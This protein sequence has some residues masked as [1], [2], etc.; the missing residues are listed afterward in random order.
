MFHY[1]TV[2]AQAR[3]LAFFLGG[4]GR[5]LRGRFRIVPYEE[6]LPAG[7]RAELPRGHY[8]FTCINVG[9]G[10][11]NP[12]S[13]VRVAAN[14]LHARLVELHGPGR[15]LTHPDR[16]LGRYDLLKEL[17]RRGINRFDAWRPGEAP[18]RFPAF[19]RDGPGWSTRE[20]ALLDE[21]RYRAALAAEEPGNDRLAVEFCDTA[22]H[23]G[24]YRKYGALVIGG[25]VV[26]RH[27]FFSRSWF[28]KSSTSFP[29]PGHLREELA[30]LESNPH[31]GLMREACRIGGFG[32]GRVD[33]SLLDG[34]PQIWEINHT[35]LLAF[36][37]GSHVD[38][39]R[40]VNQRFAELFSS[41]LDRL[42]SS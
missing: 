14:A 25:E 34:K 24:W 33:F 35:P 36:A 22:S 3:S 17:H 9:L 40:D 15:V 31:A 12:P 5:A 7:A 23:D 2:A 42:E 16:T 41:A 10:S 20:P 30:Y 29:G 32:Y 19:L 1:L 37:M 6:I 13:A 26:P 11:H 8:I 39:R 21:E 28:V 38:L 4:Y 18:G 27:L